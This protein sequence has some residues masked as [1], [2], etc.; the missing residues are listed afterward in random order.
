MH[1]WNGAFECEHKS[2][3]QLE[4]KVNIFVSEKSEREKAKG[5]GVLVVVVGV[6]HRVYNND[7]YHHQR[8][9]KRFIHSTNGA[10]ARGT[11]TN[12]HYHST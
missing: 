8:M 3:T 9:V 10:K 5:E 7:K 6:R 12:Y 2:L 11:Y 1:V 4:Q